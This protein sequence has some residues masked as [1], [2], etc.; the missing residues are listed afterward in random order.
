MRYD[1]STAQCQ[2]FTFKEGLLSKVAHD[3]RIDVARFQID[4]A[5]DV[6]SVRAELDARSLR[7]VTAMS[8]GKDNPGALSDADKRK[9]EGQIVA[10]VLHANQHETIT[11][12]S[13]SCTKK[14]EGYDITGKLTL[15]GVTQRIQM[16]ARAE[17]GQHVAEVTV[18]QPDFGITP[19][20][21]MMGTLR[22]KPDV[23]VRVTLPRVE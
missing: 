5:P 4:T 16:F 6:P 13:E 22:V 1:P 11:F 2:V 20:K 23:R 10:D 7:V 17:A 12:V 3:L 9:I 15:H 14:A 19:F 8:D 21:A 18:H